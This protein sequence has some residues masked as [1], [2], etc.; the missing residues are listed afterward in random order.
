MT[1]PV[2]PLKGRIGHPICLD[3]STEDPNAVLWAIFLG[4]ADGFGFKV[5]RL[6]GLTKMTTTRDLRAIRSMPHS[7]DDAWGGDFIA[8]RA[9]IRLRRW[10][11]A[12]AKARGYQGPYR[13]RL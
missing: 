9:R 6:G 4:M 10:N 1:E 2:A 8:A 12:V 7:C 5:I 3:E 13:L 11:R